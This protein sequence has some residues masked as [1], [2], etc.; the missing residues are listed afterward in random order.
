[1]TNGK[2]ESKTQK[3]NKDEY[4]EWRNYETWLLNLNVTN[5]QERQNMM[6][7]LARDYITAHST[8][9]NY[10]MGKYLQTELEHIFRDSKCEIYKIDDVWTERDWYEI[11]WREIA[12]T[13]VQ[14]ATEASWRDDH[15][16]DDDEEME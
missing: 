15:K 12:E 1:M 13:Y 14:E 16:A 6:Q 2:V 5:T 4:N 8:P 9:D 3:T 11:D 7:D 10:E